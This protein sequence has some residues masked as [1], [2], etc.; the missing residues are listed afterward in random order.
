MESE[1]KAKCLVCV[2]CGSGLLLMKPYLKG[3]WEQSPGSQ[4]G[5]VSTD[6]SLFPGGNP[7]PA[8]LCGACGA[9]LTF[10]DNQEV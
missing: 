8:R 1:W 5:L 10:S 7:A 4:E 6:L 3:D 2:C 9:S